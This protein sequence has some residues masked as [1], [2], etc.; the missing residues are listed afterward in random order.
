MSYQLDPETMDSAHAE[1]RAV[2]VCCPPHGQM[3]LT[4]P[5]PS[6]SER[7]GRNRTACRPVLHFTA[8]GVSGP[9]LCR[10]VEVTPSVLRPG[11]KTATGTHNRACFCEQPCKKEPKKFELGI[12]YTQFYLH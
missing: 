6:D 7:A 1:L 4:G 10:K 12:Q 2:F 5:E 9:L 11:D 3:S 8:L